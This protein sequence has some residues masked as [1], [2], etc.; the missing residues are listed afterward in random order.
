MSNYSSQYRMNTNDF[1]KPNKHVDYY[2]TFGGKLKVISDFDGRIMSFDEFV[3]LINIIV[4][5]NDV[6]RNNQYKT[7]LPHMTLDGVHLYDNCNDDN[8]IAVVYRCGYERFKIHYCA[9]CS[10]WF[11]SY[12]IVC[13]AD[14][15]IE[16]ES[17]NQINDLQLNSNLTAKNVIE[18]L[19]NTM[20]MLDY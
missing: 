1:G 15:D 3:T 4:A 17:I 18:W 5:V 14:G 11:V 7:K 6:Y 12:Y 19:F 2:D 9:P 8:N 10:N 16:R 20:S 13:N